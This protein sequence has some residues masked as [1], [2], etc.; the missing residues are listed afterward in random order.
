MRA[1]LQGLLV[2][3]ESGPVCGYINMYAALHAMAAKPPSLSAFLQE[4]GAKFL[5][6]E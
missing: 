3:H 4:V 5:W 2:S 1:Y 6:N